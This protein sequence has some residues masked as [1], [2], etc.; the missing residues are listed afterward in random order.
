M[1]STTLKPIR[2]ASPHSSLTLRTHT[3]AQR[4]GVLR[5]TGLCACRT[6]G[7]GGLGGTHVEEDLGAVRGLAPRGAFRRDSTLADVPTDRAV[8]VKDLATRPE[9]GLRVLL[10]KARGGLFAILGAVVTHVGA[11]EALRPASH[12]VCSSLEAGAGAGKGEAAQGCCEHAQ[13]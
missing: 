5:S 7:K 2:R 13:G 4:A 3:S 12:D 10:G 9:S 6:R 11:E 8:G 1:A